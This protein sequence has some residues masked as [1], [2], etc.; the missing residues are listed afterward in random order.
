MGPVKVPWLRD[1]IQGDNSNLVI[2]T[3]I[4]PAVGI[5]CAC[6]P[7]IAPALSRKLIKKRFGRGGERGGPVGPGGSSHSFLRKLFRS[8]NPK[9]SGEA[10]PDDNLPLSRVSSDHSHPKESVRNDKGKHGF[11]QISNASINYNAFVVQSNVK[12]N[13]KPSRPVT[14]QH[15]TPVPAYKDANKEFDDD[16]THRF[17]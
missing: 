16:G 17:G 10:A 15:Q 13:V 6:F 7:V 11:S 4:E 12:S 14:G 8:K 5:L 9:K 1:S 2:W 3:A